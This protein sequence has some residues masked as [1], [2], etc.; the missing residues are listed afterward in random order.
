MDST[1]V[2]CP[3]CKHAPS[4]PWLVRV[5]SGPDR[6]KIEAACVHPVHHQPPALA[7]FDYARWYTS[8]DAQAVRERL[9]A[10]ERAVRRGFVLKL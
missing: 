2:R 9:A 4:D 8:S 3:V 7:L 10:V 1:I 5:L 6:G